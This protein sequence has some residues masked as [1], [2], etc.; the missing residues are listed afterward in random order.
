MKVFWQS[1]KGFSLPE[2]ILALTIVAILG[3]ILVSLLNST[4]S[5][6]YDQSVKVKQGLSLNQASKELTSL[7]KSSAG[8]ATQYPPSGA[9]QYST[10]SQT[11]VLKIPSLNQSGGII[12]Q[13]FDYA[14]ITKDSSN[15]KIMRK[16]I[17]VDPLSQRKSEDKV[18]STSL[19]KLTFIYLDSSN[20]AV[21]PA[22][23]VRINFTI[24]LAENIN[25]TQNESSSSGTAN[26]KN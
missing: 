1:N 19:K 11:L 14:I 20:T 5:V 2:L 26:L 6:F 10:N 13:I 7:I 25:F 18:L 21:S 23:A 8:I 3:G 9:A 15:P 12:D 24:K 17:F 22:E 4:N 16:K